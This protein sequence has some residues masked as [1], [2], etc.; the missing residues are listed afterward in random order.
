VTLRCC[1]SSHLLHTDKSLQAS[2]CGS[3]DINSAAAFLGVPKRRVCD[4]VE[5][6]EGISLIGRR[7][8]NVVGWKGLESNQSNVRPY[9]DPAAKNDLNEIRGEISALIREEESLDKWIADLLKMSTRGIAVQSSD[10]IRAAAHPESE[11]PST[12]AMVVNETT[13]LPRQTFLA[14]H[15]PYHSVAQVPM[16]SITEAN[17]WQLYVGKVKGLPELGFD[18]CNDN[19]SKRQKLAL[20]KRGHR[21]TRGPLDADTI[22]IFLLPVQ[23]DESEHVLKSKGADK[24]DVQQKETD[25]RLYAPNE[26]EVD[27]LANEGVADFF[28]G[29]IQEDY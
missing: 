18:E 4:V 26:W 5:I 2:E 21:E 7:T 27:A 8:K 13:G 15:A 10:I 14:I 24:I 19:S 17:E 20:Q 23:Y 12:M 3:L 11:E 16:K 6:L 9:I 22:Q 29:P 1:C 28:A 25:F